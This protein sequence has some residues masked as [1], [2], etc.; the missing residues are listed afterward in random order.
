VALTQTNAKVMIFD[1]NGD[2]LNRELWVKKIVVA[3][4]TAK[5]ALTISNYASTAYLFNSVVPS[6]CNLQLDFS[7]YPKGFKVTGLKLTAIPTGG[8]MYV[9]L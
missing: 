4:N 2:S 1:T 8:K 6:L 7:A 9:Y 3:G 5:A